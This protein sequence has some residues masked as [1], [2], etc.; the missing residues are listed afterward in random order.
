MVAVQKIKHSE[1]LSHPFSTQTLERTKVEDLILQKNRSFH[2]QSIYAGSWG[3]SGCVCRNR[4]RFKLPASKTAHFSTTPPTHLDQSLTSVYL[5]ETSCS[6]KLSDGG[7]LFICS[8]VSSRFWLAPDYF[9]ILAVYFP[10]FLH[11]IS[12]YLSIIFMPM[13]PS[14]S[15]NVCCHFISVGF[16]LSHFYITQ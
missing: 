6:Q 14:K 9:D 10:S 16:L 13:Q 12:I 7:S 15:T 1:R 11:F 2:L 4:P 3:R 5:R 8:T